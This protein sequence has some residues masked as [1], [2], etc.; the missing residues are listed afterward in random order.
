MTKKI[1]FTERAKKQIEKITAKNDSKKSILGFLLKEV[2]A[3]VLNIILV[4][5][6]Q[7]QTMMFCLIKL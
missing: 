6:T 3:Q 2:V 5:T 4:S 1:E 7:L